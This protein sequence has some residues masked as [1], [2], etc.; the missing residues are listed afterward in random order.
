MEID[1]IITVLL[2]TNMFVGGIMGLLLDNTVPGSLEERGIRLW[3]EQLG[4]TGVEN[5][6][7]AAMSVYDLPFGLKRLSKYKFAKYVPF[8]PYYPEPEQVELGATREYSG[9]TAL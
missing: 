8:L 9:S 4:V 5:S 3:R 7:I 1:Q 6:V 2:K